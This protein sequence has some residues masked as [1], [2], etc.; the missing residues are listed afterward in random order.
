MKLN[1][2]PT[3]FLLTLSTGGGVQAS[4][5]DMLILVLNG[6]A[7]H[8]KIINFIKLFEAYMLAS[9]SG[10]AATEGEL[11]DMDK[12]NPTLNWTKC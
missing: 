12:R 9:I 3:F 5:W 2:N 1:D 7:F 10:G 8:D 6:L 4:P 11:K